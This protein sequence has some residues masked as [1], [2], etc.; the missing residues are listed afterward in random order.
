MN[1][2][3]VEEK[4]WKR[5]E[6]KQSKDDAYHIFFRLLLSFYPFFSKTKLLRR[7]VNVINRIFHSTLFI[8][9]L[10][11][12]W[13][14]A[15]EIRKKDTCFHSLFVWLVQMEENKWKNHIK[16]DIAIIKISFSHGAINRTLWVHF[17]R[18]NEQVKIPVNNYYHWIA[19]FW[20]NFDL[21]VWKLCIVFECG[22]IKNELW[23]DT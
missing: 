8:M 1:I 20:M 18:R 21:C 7:L 13:W 15:N 11:E 4:K 9:M 6:M 14:L 23:M 3:R 12:C 10:Y 5:V 22:E 17:K 2:I 19:I 16:F